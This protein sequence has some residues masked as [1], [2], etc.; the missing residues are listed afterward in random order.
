M[1]REWGRD[2][3]YTFMSRER[4]EGYADV[5]AYVLKLGYNIPKTNIKTT[6]S[7]GYVD[8][9][10]ITDVAKN[11][12]GMPSYTQLNIDIRYEFTGF[13]TGLGAQLLYVY[14][15]KVGNTSVSEKY[16]INK[17]NMSLWNLVLNYN[18]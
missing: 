10:E 16:I 13:L 5:N 15:N 9:P 18:F 4:N 11:K 6:T 1:P 17:V 2:P 8:L 12:Y 14:K 3:F 7:F